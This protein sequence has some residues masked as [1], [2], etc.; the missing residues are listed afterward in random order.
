MIRLTPRA[1]E[2]TRS[3]MCAGRMMTCRK[4]SV[5]S[6]ESKIRVLRRLIMASLAD[7]WLFC[8]SY[9]NVDAFCIDL[10]SECLAVV[11]DLSFLT[12]LLLP[13]VLHHD[14]RNA[15]PGR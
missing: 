7:C 8:S 15:R 10:L 14:L 9:C 4:G 2:V 13:S 1:S 5:L 6:S 3:S 11:V 12:F